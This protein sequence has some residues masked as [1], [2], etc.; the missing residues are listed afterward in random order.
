MLSA[1]IPNNVRKKVYARDGYRCA[2]CD[3]TVGLQIH[4]VIPRGCGG[5]S[6]P[7]NLITLCAYCHSHVHGRPLYDYETDVTADDM[8][9]FC[10]EYL[11]DYYAEDRDYCPFG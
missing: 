10:V 7:Y 9:Q 11:G 2:L 8:E 6:T 1:K 5:N 4:H 3:S